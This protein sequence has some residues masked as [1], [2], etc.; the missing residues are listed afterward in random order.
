M[1]TLQIGNLTARLPI[2]Q[3]GMGIG[4][5]LSGLAAAVANEGGIGVISATGLSLLYAKASDSYVEAGNR[6]LKEEIRKA[7][8]KSN[9]IIGVNIMV[10]LTNFTELVKTCIAEK[11]DIIF[12]GAGLPLDLPSFLTKDDAT[13]LV[14]IVSSARAAKLICQKW[15]NS[16]QYLPDAIVLEGPKAGGHLGYKESEL[17]APSFSLEA[18]L[19]LVIA[20]VSSFEEKFHKTIPVIAAGGIYTGED[21]YRMMELGASGVQLG[22][23]FVATDECDADI[24]FKEA[25]VNARQQDIRIIKSPVGMPGRAIQSP[26]LQKAKDGTEHPKHCPFHCIRTCDINTSPYCIA[27][28]LYN[29]YKGNFEKGFAFAGSNAFRVDRITSVKETMKELISEF[30]KSSEAVEFE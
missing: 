4:V 21:I 2:I 26:F 19:P 5:S 22:T 28:A 8:E 24:A 9:G 7:R 14:P 17:E 16:Y 27:I 29:A 25:Y 3:G 10:A 23:R 15:V 1:R 12:C 18:Q 6:G 30:E 13:K 11:V 20:E